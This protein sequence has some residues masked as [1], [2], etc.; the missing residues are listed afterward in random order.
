MHLAYVAVFL[1]DESFP[2]FF[3]LVSFLLKSGNY[4]V[5]RAQLSFR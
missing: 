2:F 5:D 4:V 1:C 3:H